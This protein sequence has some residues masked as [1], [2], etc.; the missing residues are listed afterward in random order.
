MRGRNLS[1]MDMILLIVINNRW[2]IDFATFQNLNIDQVVSKENIE[3]MEITIRETKGR[4]L[5]T[6]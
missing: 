6:D 2:T 4:T 5:V 3:E 1:Q